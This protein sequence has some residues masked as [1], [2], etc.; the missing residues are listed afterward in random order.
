[1]L[2]TVGLGWPL[3]DQYVE[4]LTQVT[5]D[6]IQAVARK[7][8]TSDNLTVAILDPQP[9]A[10]DTKTSTKCAGAVPHVR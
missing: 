2:E 3:V 7:Y 8:L 5:P 6:Q 1:M 9:M 4:R 10:A